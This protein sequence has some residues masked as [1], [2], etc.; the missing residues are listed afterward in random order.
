MHLPETR[1]TLEDY[2]AGIN[3]LYEAGAFRR[4][5]LSNYDPQDVEEVI[6]VCKEHNYVLPTVYQGQHRTHL[7]A[8]RPLPSF[9]SP[10]SSPLDH[11]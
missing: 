5:G 7:I 4:F 3:A 9:P 8:P 1:T 10:A 11:A 6:R 2:L